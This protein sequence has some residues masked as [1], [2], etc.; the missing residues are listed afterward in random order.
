MAVGYRL[1][2]PS[3]EL[4]P[5]YSFWSALLRL[6]HRIK[7]SGRKA[8]I[9]RDQGKTWGPE[10]NAREAFR[11]MRNEAKRE[12]VGTVWW[13][14][15]ANNNIIRFRKVHY[16]P[17]TIDTQG[18]NNVDKAYTEIFNR[19][20]GLENWGICVCRDIAGTSTTSQ[21]AYCNAIDIHGTPSQM[22]EI[23]RWAEANFTRLNVYTIIFN[24]QAFSKPTPYWHFYGGVN[25]HTDHVHLDF[26]PQGSGFPTACG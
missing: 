21:H 5:R 26:D 7:E 3:G 1:T 6:R 12:P 19:W 18:N 15:L 13:I 10:R 25:P 23:S 20:K 4:S 2:K 22:F 14:K 24:R 9:S 8:K 11:I 16:N 17:P